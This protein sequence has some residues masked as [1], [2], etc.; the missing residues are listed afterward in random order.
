M[1]QSLK[2]VHH[3][4]QYCQ[5]IDY[6]PFVI[7]VL[8]F[9]RWHQCQKN[10]TG[11]KNAVACENSSERS[12]TI[13]TG[14]DCKCSNA[15]ENGPSL[16]PGDR[17]DSQTAAY[18]TPTATACPGRCQCQSGATRLS[19]IHKDNSSVGR[20]EIPDIGWNQ[21]FFS[22]SRTHPFVTGFCLVFF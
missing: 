8:F 4:F 10:E 12:S 1:H 3:P 14:P 5:T 19:S 20:V 21:G 7:V 17:R 16:K 22:C 6:M 9:S 2:K 13:W 15:E 11:C 18:G